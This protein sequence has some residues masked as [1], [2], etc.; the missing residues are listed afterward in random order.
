[1]NEDIN[2]KKA[3]FN[4]LSEELSRRSR[5]DDFPQDKLQKLLKLK[6]QTAK[7]IGREARE[8]EKLPQVVKNVTD[9]INT[10]EIMGIV[11]ET[12]EHIDTKSITKKIPKAT[13]NI[14]KRIVQKLPD[15][16]EYAASIAKKRALLKAAKKGIGKFAKTGMKSLPLVGGL[17]AALMS[18]D[19]SAAVPVLGDVEPV[20]PKE[21]SPSSV[22]EDMSADPI[23]RLKAI[24]ALQKRKMEE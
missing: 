14:E 15:A 19:A 11:P 4:K 21:G 20:G 18:D 2:R 22:I 24:R 6:D 3:L 16:G 10:N 7:A 8:L 5:E 12:T 23:E 1:M 13:Q 17:A 9:K